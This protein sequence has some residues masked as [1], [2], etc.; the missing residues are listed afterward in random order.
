MGNRILSA[1]AI[2]LELRSS[3]EMRR[4]TEDERRRSIELEDAAVEAL[5]EH[6]WPGN[7]RE[8]EATLERALLLYREGAKLG[9]EEIREALTP[10]VLG[11]V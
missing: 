1:A 7:F 10:P 2:P 4:A 9:A 5:S 11:A 8:L 3:E 6:S